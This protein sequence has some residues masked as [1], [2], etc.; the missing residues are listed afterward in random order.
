M[1]GHIVYYLQVCVKIHAYP[2]AC[3]SE[4]SFDSVTDQ[5]Q[6]VVSDMIHSGYFVRFQVIITYIISFLSYNLHLSYG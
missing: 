6:Y 3:V 5:L 4:Q 1:L 2:T